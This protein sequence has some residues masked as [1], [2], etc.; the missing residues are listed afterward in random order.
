[1][2]ARVSTGDI[3]DRL[4]VRFDEIRQR[5]RIIQQAAKQIPEGPI[6][7]V[8]THVPVRVPPGKA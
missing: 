6:M 4:M 8:K 5:I 3:Y 7:S 2:S 1:M